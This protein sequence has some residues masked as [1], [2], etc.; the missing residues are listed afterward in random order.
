MNQLAVVCNQSFELLPQKAMFWKEQEALVL[1]DLHLGKSAHF[2]K[3]GIAIPKRANEEILWTL[4]N[5][6]LKHKPKQVLIIGDL[7]H[8]DINNEWAEFVDFR[9]NVKEVKFHLILGN[10]DTF[11]LELLSEANIEVSESY[12]LDGIT[13]V[14][15]PEDA[16]QTGYTISGHIHPAVRM[17]GKGKQSVRLACFCFGQ[18]LGLLPSFGYFTGSFT[19]KPKKA[20]RVFVT[21][22]K[23]VIE[24]N[25]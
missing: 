9:M 23:D 4:S 10:H 8:S 11:D 21:T 25:L 17:K 19:I 14:H 6:I 20:D 22:G 12:T 1:S 15:D 7:F 3:N 24:V 2:R 13:F 5:L 16:P 18:L